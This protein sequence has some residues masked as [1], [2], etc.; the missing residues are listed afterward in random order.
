MP[1]YC[2][3][4]GEA[5]QENAAFCGSCGAELH[6]DQDGDAGAG[7]RQQTRHQGD[8]W[9]GQ[10]TQQRQPRGSPV[11][12]KNAVDTLSQGFSWLLSE[13]P[14][15]GVFVVGALISGLLQIAVPALGFLGLV[16]NAIVGAIAFIAVERKLNQEPFIISNAFNEALEQIVPL[17]VVAI[18]YGIAVA[19]GFVLL[20]IPG[21]YLGARLALALPACIL[22]SQGI[23]ESL[24]TSWEVADGNL[25]KIIG[26]FLLYFGVSV[27]I[28]GGAVATVGPETAT[29]PV[30]ILV[31]SVIGAVVAG[32]YNLAIGRVY[33]E[34]RH[35]QEPPR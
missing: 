33:L 14:L 17:V 5:V 24:S 30:F 22:D 2:P 4:C 8:D 20:I 25:G 31:T 35:R 21:I 15:I 23:G 9:G 3:N 34:N 12:R 27:L 18:V 1:E 19:V 28:S 16:V 10:A 29:D 11:Q 13:P 6:G 26:I 7:G 32:G